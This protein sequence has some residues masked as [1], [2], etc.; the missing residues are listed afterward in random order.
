MAL[1]L[2]S[3]IPAARK[4]PFPW[5]EPRP[6]AEHASEEK[7]GTNLYAYVRGSPVNLIDPNGTESIGDW[8][9]KK[10]EGAKAVAS[11][12]G[13]R[14]KQV[15]SQIGEGYERYEKTRGS[16]WDRAKAALDPGMPSLTMHP[17]YVKDQGLLESVPEI[18]AL[19]EAK[20]VSTAMQ[21]G[22]YATATERFLHWRDAAEASAQ[23]IMGAGAGIFGA[24]EAA[25]A[26]ELSGARGQPS[27]TRASAPRASFGS[28]ARPPEL[29]AR[30]KPPSL[31]REGI[32]YDL[33]HEAKH[34]EGTP[35]TQKLMAKEGAVH[36]FN[37]QPTLE[38]VK[39]ALVAQGEFTG[40][41]RGTQR[42]GM[43]FEEP[44][45]SRVS[46]TGERIPLHYAEAKLDPKTGK[47]HIIPRT[48]PSKR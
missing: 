42:F 39:G 29:A 11:D 16:F 23:D 30:L 8:F 13:A 12:L 46:S 4:V 6:R 38:R 2:G 36:V 34:L 1:D 43:R 26:S 27:T 25:E 33:R 44:I 40:V 32:S 31:A 17:D 24:A 22:D 37:D 45:G 21:K 14:A 15:G 5:A 48:G 18:R 41:V 47:Y 7:I 35:A 19:H 10:V 28:K 20:R 9:H 3:V